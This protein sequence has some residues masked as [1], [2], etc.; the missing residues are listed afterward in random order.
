LVADFSFT[1]VDGHLSKQHPAKVHSSSPVS[2]VES[3]I[4]ISERGIY[5]ASP[6]K[7]VRTLK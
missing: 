3:S 4:L 7:A 6:V 2:P 1:Q 5:A